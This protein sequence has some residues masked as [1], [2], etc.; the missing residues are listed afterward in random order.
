MNVLRA[1]AA[2]LLCLV[3]PLAEPATDGDAA[4]AEI[5]R[6]WSGAFDNQRQ[7]ASHLERG[8]PA[9]PELTRERRSMS[10]HRLD[11]PQFGRTVLY[12]EE[13]RDSAPA[14]AHRQRVVSLVVDPAS[15]QIRAEQWFF[16]AGPTYDRKPLDPQAVARMPRS[17]LRRV[18]ECDLFF[19]HEPAFDRYRG[20]MR[21]R[22]CE[23][24]HEVDGRVYAEFDML[25]YPD[26]LWYR[27]R[28]LRVRDGS[29]RGEIDGFSWLLFDRRDQPSILPAIATQQGVWQGTFRRYDADGRLVAEFPSEIVA[30]IYPDG[31]RL[32]YHQTN[33]YRAAGEPEQR[34]DSY[35]EV[36][37]GRVWFSN[38]RLDGWSMDMPGDASGRGAV[39]FMA[40]K[41][42]SDQSVYEIITR[43]EDGSRRSR[44]TQYFA[45]GALLRRTLIDERKVT[46]DWRA[47]D[48]ARA[49]R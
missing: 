44:A 43:S 13:F 7:V 42:G 4:I 49:A 10:V 25:L 26:Q 9:A 22:A 17:A 48:A 21:P 5:A 40:Y 14:L 34:I 27:D 38:E 24:D 2:V 11:A 46:D 47:W 31:A 6:R 23:Y 16:N 12:Y 30:R 8:P 3:S 28:S 41:D 18:P 29:I 36:R 20:S 39:L 15:G 37:D 1:W 35:G 33:I 19:V 45:A 32:R